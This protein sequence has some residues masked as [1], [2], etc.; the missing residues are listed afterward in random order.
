MALLHRVGI[1]ALLAV[2]VSGEAQAQDKPGSKEST[3]ASS[4]AS[5]PS[6]RN[7]LASVPVAPITIYTK[8]KAPATPKVG[9]LP[10]KESVTQ[11]GITWTFEK[12]VPVGRF[13]NGD[14]Y[15]VGAATVK[16]IDPKPLF[17]KDVPESDLDVNDKK[18]VKDGKYV[19]NGSML[20]P[21]ARQAMAYDSGLR[22]SFAPDL[23]SAP[24][25]AL[26]PGDVLVST[27]SLK[28]GEK[29]AIVGYGNGSLSRAKH[30]NCPIKVAAA[31]TC[32][33]EPLAPDAFRP[34]Y[35]DANRTVYYSHNLRRDLLPRLARIDKV[36][37]PLKFAGIFGRMWLN[38]G[39]FGFDEPMENMPHY[40]Q[41]VGQAV[42]GAALLL[43]LD[44][45][46]EE[47]EPLLV[48]FVQ[49][50]IDYWGLVK[51]GHHGWE[52]FGGH[53]SGRKLPI[54]LAGTLLGDE[55]M[56]APGTSCPKAE[57]GEDNQTA[58][59]EGWTGAKAIFT[60]HGAV[61]TLTGKSARPKTG[62]YE[63]MHPSLWN[64]DGRSDTG[65]EAYRRCCT[66][67]CWAGEALALR[68]LK[69]EKPWGHDAFLDY[70]DRWMTEDDKPAR[71][72]IKK[73]I[74]NEYTQYFFEGNPGE[75]WIGEMWKKY[76][77]LSSAPTDGWKTLKPNAGGW[78]APALMPADPNAKPFEKKPA[79]K[80]GQDASPGGDERQ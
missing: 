14:F 67:N 26:K 72:E 20:N 53:G 15:V 34:G 19:R 25:Y 55:A 31:L 50:G 2:I 64:R 68:I 80:T 79:A 73:Y 75:A 27:I 44:F 33:A 29:A 65:S 69:L 1:A 36:P 4:P 46:P 32:V 74:G 18:L 57:F 70:M 43:C 63:Q 42:S 3:A 60:G 7:D 56:A 9:D 41:Q 30:D 62:P 24:P 52:G 39:F 59:G 49:V 16:A 54:V 13:I 17:G 23:V 10:L 6:R 35:S 51:S 8:E 58:Y 47:L 61:S 22:Q 40:G 45:K 78:T 5:A 37:D 12:P 28:M 21:P 77:S 38:P 66:S 11:Y 71:E 48:H 76:R